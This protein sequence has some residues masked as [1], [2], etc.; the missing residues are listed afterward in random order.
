M[1]RWKKDQTDVEY[2]REQYRRL[3]GKRDDG[4]IVRVNS[5]EQWKLAEMML[6]HGFTIAETARVTRMSYN[7]TWKIAH[8]HFS[9]GSLLDDGE[10]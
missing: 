9:G 2:R 1:G 4:L 6:S 8:G 5:P 10:E 7:M 3:Y